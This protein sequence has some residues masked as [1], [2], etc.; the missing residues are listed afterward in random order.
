VNF[1]VLFEGAEMSDFKDALRN[2]DVQA[3]SFSEEEAFKRDLQLVISENYI[4][5]VF[6]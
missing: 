6:L 3:I 2:I 4:N 1:D 5:E